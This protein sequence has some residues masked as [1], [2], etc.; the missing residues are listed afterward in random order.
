M[1]AISVL[2]GISA[3]VLVGVFSFSL[4]TMKQEVQEQPEVKEALHK[5]L[6]A[7]E[8]D[9]LKQ[10]AQLDATLQEVAAL[11]Y[12]LE[13]LKAN[14]VVE[15]AEPVVID[16]PVVEEEIDPALK[17]R[18]DRKVK[19]IESA[20]LMAK[21]N[22][23]YAED[24]FASVNV[25]SV[26]QVQEGVSFAIRREGSIIGQLEVTTVEGREAIADALPKTF[27]NGV[28]DIRPGDELILPPL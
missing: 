26:D 14:Q 20:L 10:Q 6:L 16:P 23:F 22:K 11:K 12:E 18:M 27:I 28:L 9:K 24:G 19:M 15:V 13:A 8:Q 4:G 5:E 17:R 2:I 1:N 21:V 3:I 25:I 7:I